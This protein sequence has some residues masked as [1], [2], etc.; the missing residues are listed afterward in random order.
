MSTF[1]IDGSL[2]KQMIINGAVNLENNSDYID[3]LNVF[4]V[5]D[6][7]TGTNM[8]LTLSS[9]A[10]EMANLESKSISEVAKKLSR[11]LLM[12]A[13][14]NSGVILSQLFRGFSNGLEGEDVADSIVFARALKKGVETAY[15]AVMKPVEGTMLTVS[16]ESADEI[17]RMANP[18]MS[19]EELL[20]R[21]VNEAKRSLKRTPDLLPVLK[22]VGVVDSGGAGLVVIY[23]IGRASCRER[24]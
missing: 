1:K 17:S 11:G 15:K 19:F 12:G 24:V 16:R 21:L 20:Q 23:E 14:G 3:Q 5:P 8:K 4:P 6:G 7:D 9:G 18:E 22:E 10:K 2:F 13:R